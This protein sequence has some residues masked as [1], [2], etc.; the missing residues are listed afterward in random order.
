MHSIL[1]RFLT[2]TQLADKCQ[3]YCMH[4]F[5]WIAINPTFTW[6]YVV[7]WTANWYC[8][9]QLDCCNT[10]S[11]YFRGRKYLRNIIKLFE[12]MHRNMAWAICQ[13]VILQDCVR[14]SKEYQRINV[15]YTS[16]QFMA[17]FKA[18][19]E[20]GTV[21]SLGKSSSPWLYNC[22][23]YHTLKLNETHVDIF[24]IYTTFIEVEKQ[25]QIDK[26]FGSGQK[27]R[28]IINVYH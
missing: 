28:Y 13:T 15:K 10:R 1:K 6:A 14:A 16:M 23:T 4:H 17:Y 25:Q 24:F 20:R 2:Q 5:G 26:C 19:K 27:P 3:V 8:K 21:E 9:M 18:D 7:M 22:H 11:S 12:K